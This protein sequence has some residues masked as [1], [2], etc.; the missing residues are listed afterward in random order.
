MI[1]KASYLLCTLIAILA[2]CICVISW[3][4]V[5]DAREFLFALAS[6]DPSTA[7]NQDA[8]KIANRFQTHISP[9][10]SKCLPE[11]CEYAFHF[12]NSPLS[13]LRLAPLSRMNGGIKLH[14][15]KLQLVAVNFHQQPNPRLDVNVWEFPSS[16]ELPPF[17]AELVERSGDPN[18]ITVHMSGEAMQNQRRAAFALHA[19]CLARIGGCRSI[20]QIAPDLFRIATRR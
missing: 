13:F 19:A 8:E 3:R 12:T 7:T 6:L 15:G 11:L 2:G 16:P 20:Q 17:Q 18:F 14:D 5:T 9:G 10:P 1:R 4:T